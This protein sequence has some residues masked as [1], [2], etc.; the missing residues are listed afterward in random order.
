M[1]NLA[2]IDDTDLDVADVKVKLTPREREILDWVKQ[3]KS[4]VD[5]AEILSISPR[6]IEFHIANV[7]NKLGASNRVSAVVIAMRRGI[8]GS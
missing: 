2:V 6:T 4:Y 8:L 5:I 7:M 1:I 3:G